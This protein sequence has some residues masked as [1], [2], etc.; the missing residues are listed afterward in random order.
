[1]QFS[2]DYDSDT[3]KLMTAALDDAW[4][5]VGRSALSK[6]LTDKAVRTAM[7]IRIMAAVRAG[8]REPLRLKELA[9][10]VVDR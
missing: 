4:A 6:G 2:S 8:E 1:M 10:D 3:L 7:A 9:L 5:N